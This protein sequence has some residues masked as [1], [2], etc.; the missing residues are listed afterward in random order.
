ML[1]EKEFIA[2]QLKC[3]Y[4]SWP[5]TQIEPGIYGCKGRRREGEPPHMPHILYLNSIPDEVS[6]SNWVLV[7]SGVPEWAKV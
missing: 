7:D 5:L 2:Q 4:C 3:P 6:A 1:L